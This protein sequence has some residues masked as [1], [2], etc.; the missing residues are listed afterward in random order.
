[1]KALVNQVEGPFARS[2]IACDEPV[3]PGTFSGSQWCGDRLKVLQE[4]FFLSQHGQ[5]QESFAMLCSLSFMAIIAGAFG[6]K[7]V[8]LIGLI[9]TMVSVVLFVFASSSPSLGR[10]LFAYG[11]G[12]QGLYPLDYIQGMIVLDMSMQLGGDAQSTFELAGYKE[13]A[14]NLLWSIGLG[15][16][17]QL[18][19]LT[20]YAPV[21][22]SILMLNGLVFLLALL[23]F[24]ET[25]V[26]PKKAV[27]PV[28]EQKVAAKQDLLQEGQPAKP[29]ETN[30]DTHKE[31]NAQPEHKTLLAEEP[32]R[33]ESAFRKV[34]TEV[35]SYGGLARDFRARRYLVTKFLEGSFSNPFIF[36]I[37]PVQLMA[38]HGW[39][40]SMVTILLVT[41]QPLNL[42]CMP[43]YTKIQDR[44]GMHTTYLLAIGAL[45]VGFWTMCLGACVPYHGDKL[46]VLGLLNAAFWSGFN[47]MRGYVDSRF[48]EQEQVSRFINVQWIM[49]YFQGMFL[50]PMYATLFNP[51]AQTYLEKAR[52]NIV[53]SLICLFNIVLVFNLIYYMADRTEGFGVTLDNMD[54]G[55]AAINRIFALLRQ[56]RP[57]LG[58]VTPDGPQ[59]YHELDEALWHELGFREAFWGLSAVECGGPFW[60][61][62]HMGMVVSQKNT[63]PKAFAEVLEKLELAVEKAE[64]WAAIPDAG[65]E[66]APDGKKDA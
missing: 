33:E 36:G 20:R 65:A 18:V 38:Y 25:L 12:L 48:C 56:K 3:L 21:W 44:L 37:M 50:G 19:E 55:W 30:R 27:A 51:W 5:A 43:L 32:E 39:S 26:R 45:T 24:P 4:G 64:K 22:L 10:S 53:M 6:R 16:V 14:S 31:D 28:D 60:N 2:L 17:V 63:G 8:V 34:V 11:Q 7:V 46:V 15:N 23:M 40:Q 29:V 62:D 54:R 1:M 58:K 9:G 47:A 13:T 49:G 42:L 35:V 57:L 41:C 61:K 59:V 66:P 52:P